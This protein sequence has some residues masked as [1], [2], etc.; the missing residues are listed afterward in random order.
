[1]LEKLQVMEEL[2]ELEELEVMEVLE[3]GGREEREILCPGEEVGEEETHSRVE[4]EEE[5]EEV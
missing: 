2:E 4:V 3:V 5:A 1:M